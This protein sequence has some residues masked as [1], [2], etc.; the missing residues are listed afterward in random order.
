MNAKVGNKIEKISLSSPMFVTATEPSFTSFHRT[1]VRFVF[2][3]PIL[4]P[5]SL[6]HLIYERDFVF[7]PA[8]KPV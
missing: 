1:V 4:M 7:E 8:T 6:K 3:A 5:Y 2:Y